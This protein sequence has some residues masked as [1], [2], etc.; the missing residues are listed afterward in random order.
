[1]SPMTTIPA[2]GVERRHLRLLQMTAFISSLDRAAI[3]P[4]IVP[5]AKDMG[6]GV[7][8]VTLAATSYVL[9]YGAMQLVW[10]LV[11]DRVG[12]V[13]T[14]RFA[15]A[16]ACV[17]GLASALAPNLQL[18]V[19]TRALTGAA[20]AAAVPGALVYIGDT[21]PLRI[22]QGV[23]AD[24][25]TGI[26]VGFALGTLGAA[27]LSE[28]LSWR[29]AF[30][31]TAIA[32]ACITVLMARLPEP[33]RVSSI[34]LRASLPGLIHHRGTA[35]VLGLSFVEGFT[36]LG[37][38]VFLP[39]TL[40][41]SGVNTSAAGGVTAFYGVTVVIFAWV[42]KHVSRRRSAALIIV[43]GGGCAVGAFAL[44]AARQNVFT[45]FIACA[46]LGTAWPLMH[47][48]LQTWATEAEPS[49][50]AV[51]VSAF[52]GMLFLGNAGGTWIGG[53]LLATGDM[54]LLFSVAGVIALPLTICA[55]WGRA[56]QEL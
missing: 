8:A 13:R 27:V 40:Q 51:V 29:I 10:A 1:M 24:L 41:L 33:A 2:G 36:I 54:R 48:T 43:V 34:T 47:T 37:F 12:R 6:Q 31:T 18:L 16:T 45:V 7:D 44:L 20:F 46:L 15:L 19:A 55:A 30:A 14:M 22:R 38:L 52:A 28:H 49:A 9:T 50:R 5:I 26:A 42:V 39:A 53:L 56:C 23:L 17:A 3:A 11:S 35:L 4:L 32:A 25:T 21:V